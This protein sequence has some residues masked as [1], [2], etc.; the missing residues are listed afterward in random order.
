[1]RSYCSSGLRECSR[2]RDSIMLTWD[3]AGA[4]VLMLPRTPKRIGSVTLRDFSV[5]VSFGARGNVLFGGGDVRLTRTRVEGPLQRGLFLEGHRV[6]L[7]ETIVAGSGSDNHFSGHCAVNIRGMDSSSDVVAIQ[8]S[9][10]TN[11][12]NYGVCIG[13]PLANEDEEF[14][15]WLDN[16]GQLNIAALD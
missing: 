13:N 6:Y 2:L 10:V 1:M 12:P 9:V 4:S 7:N 8:H 3:L 5:G 15:V 11:S 16:N 14:Q